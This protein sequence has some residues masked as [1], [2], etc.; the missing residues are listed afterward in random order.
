M[1]RREAR[2]LMLLAV[3]MPLG[4]FVLALIGPHLIRFLR[5]LLGHP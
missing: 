1:F 4:S 3:I 2:G 5:A